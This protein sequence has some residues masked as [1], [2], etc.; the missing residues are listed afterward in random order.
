MASQRKL[1]ITYM[2]MAEEWG[3]LSYANRKKVGALIVLR[4]RIISDGYNGTPTGTCNKCEDVE[5]KTKKEVIH[6]E[7]NALMKLARS[8]NSAEGAT[9]YSTLSPCFECAKLIYQAGI[10]TVIY[11]EKYSDVEGISF[12]NSMDVNCFKL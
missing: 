8:T 7:S 9:L 2:A 4:E 5:G 11:K 10:A 1:D 12:L 6:A 3:K